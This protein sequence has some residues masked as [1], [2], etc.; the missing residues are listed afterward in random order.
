MPATVLSVILIGLLTGR[1]F[2]TDHIAVI[3]FYRTTCY[4]I[5]YSARGAVNL[6]SDG[7]DGIMVFVPYLNNNSLLIGKMFTFLAGSY[8]RIG[9]VHG[10]GSPC[11][12]RFW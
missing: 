1:C 2:V 11:R 3:H 4:F 9:V 6:T 7:T 8:G 10:G 5:R 12:C